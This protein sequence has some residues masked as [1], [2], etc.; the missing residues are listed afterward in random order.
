M[1]VNLSLLILIPYAE[2]Y[3]V[4]LQFRSIQSLSCVQLFAT[5]C[6]V[7]P[8]ASLSFT[9][10]WIL[11]KLESI[12]ISDAIQ[13]SHPLSS[14]FPPT[15]NLSQPQ[16]LFQWV[17]SSYQVAKVFELQ[18][19]HQSFQWIFRTDFL[20]DWLVWSPCS[21]KNHCDILIYLLVIPQ[22]P[23]HQ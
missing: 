22:P 4:K 2:I 21:P 20:S 11:L 9:N 5:P 15:F 8:Q 19:Q 12:W 14:P 10:S 16:S 7:A 3:S 6:T 1:W 13:P 18:L 17:N 23:P